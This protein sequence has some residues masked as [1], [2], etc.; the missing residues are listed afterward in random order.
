MP[1]EPHSPVPGQIPRRERNWVGG[2]IAVN[3]LSFAATREA[4]SIFVGR[5]ESD[6]RAQAISID[7]QCTHDK[8]GCTRI[9]SPTKA[10]HKR[11]DAMLPDKTECK[12]RATSN[13][14]SDAEDMTALASHGS[15]P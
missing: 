9:G 13:G 5:M 11:M 6:S 3:S 8:V 2:C 10:F 7:A 4:S 1:Q 12:I 14:R 15:S